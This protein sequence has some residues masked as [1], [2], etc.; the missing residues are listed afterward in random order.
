MQNSPKK[1][2]KD[3]PELSTA[4]AWPPSSA[5]NRWSQSTC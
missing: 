1:I 3:A 5:Y 2:I 4:H